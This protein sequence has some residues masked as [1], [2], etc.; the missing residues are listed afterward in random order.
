M[1]RQTRRRRRRRKLRGLQPPSRT[2]GQRRYTATRLQGC[3]STCTRCTTHPQA[4]DISRPRSPMEGDTPVAPAVGPRHGSFSCFCTTLGSSACACG[5]PTDKTQRKY[6]GNGSDLRMT[7]EVWS[8]IPSPP[9]NFPLGWCA[10]SEG[11]S[12][13]LSSRAKTERHP[14]GKKKLKNGV[15]FAGSVSRSRHLKYWQNTVSNQT[16]RLHEQCYQ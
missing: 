14:R 2:S 16:R 6:R 13:V 15:I 11:I 12:S 8:Q 9:L 4:G 3:P 5:Y 10:A 1:A 7:T